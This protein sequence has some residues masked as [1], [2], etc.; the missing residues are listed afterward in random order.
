M[1]ANTDIIKVRIVTLK[2]LKIL[3]VQ[4]FG[5]SD[6]GTDYAQNLDYSQNI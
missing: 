2:Y 1:K 6:F 4:N 5:Q 3:M